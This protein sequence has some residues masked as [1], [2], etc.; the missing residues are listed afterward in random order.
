MAETA[1]ETRTVTAEV[2]F[3][4]D[5][6]VPILIGH[7]ATFNQPYA[8]GHFRERIHPTAFDKTL[9]AN[10]DVRLLIDHEGQPLARTKSGTLLLGKDDKGL[11]VRATLDPTDPDVQRLT[12]KMRR[13]DMDQMSFAFR[14]PA[15]GD[16]WDYTGDTPDR[17]VREAALS[18]GDVS[19][20]TYPANDKAD[21]QIRAR[22]D[23]EASF[24][25][26]DAMLREIRGGKT[27]E[28]PNLLLL[29]TAFKD[30]GVDLR[31]L[32]PA[33]ATAAHVEQVAEDIGIPLELAQRI[34]EARRHAA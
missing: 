27:F 17:T 25:L 23:R 28:E 26:A 14:V 10:P 5:G 20:V 29:V 16:T 3:R 15:G 9:A 31:S 8:V 6:D 18:G 24:V 34:A 19:V 30:L 32:I 7:A 4:E 13:G 12:P 21:A 2:E 11:T 1:F 33:Q 22:D